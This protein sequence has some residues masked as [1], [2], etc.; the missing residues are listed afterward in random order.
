MSKKTNLF[1]GITVLVVW[2]IALPVMGTESD[3]HQKVKKAKAVLQEGV[4]TWNAEK[5]LAARDMFLNI[6]MTEKSSEVYLHYYIALCDYRLVTHKLT[7]SVTDEAE[8][9]IMEQIER[10]SPEFAAGVIASPVHRICNALQHGSPNGT[11][12]V[13][14]ALYHALKEAGWEDLGMVKSTDYPTKKNMWARPDMLKRYNKSELRRMVE[15]A[16]EPG[17]KLVK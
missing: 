15:Q 6:L 13:P 10:P 8:T 3:I 12:I 7:E 9:Y 4:N 14:A 5:F 2:L 17:L 16:P 1:L 11:K